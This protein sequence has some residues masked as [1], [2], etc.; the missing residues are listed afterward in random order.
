MLYGIFTTYKYFYG[1]TN[2]TEYHRVLAIDVSDDWVWRC[3][4]SYD[5]SPQYGEYS[6]I[7]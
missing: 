2:P 6:G 1:N 3:V 5:I 4:D 7:L